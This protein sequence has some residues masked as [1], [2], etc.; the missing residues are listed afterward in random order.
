[1]PGADEDRLQA[2]VE[3]ARL[4]SSNQAPLVPGSD[5]TKEIGSLMQRARGLAAL[6]VL[7]CMPAL[8][9]QSSSALAS[10]GSF[11]RYTAT[12]DWSHG[13]IAGSVIWTECNAGCETWLAL[14]YVQPT[15]YACYAEEWQDESDPNIRQ[16]YNSGGQH[17]NT[18][19]NFERL[20]QPLLPGVYG[21]RLCMI[22]VQSTRYGT[23]PDESYVGQ[24][25]LANRVMEVEA[26]APVPLPPPPS[27]AASPP[28]PTVS[29]QCILASREVR[30]LQKKL[31]RAVRRGAGVQVERKALAKAKR[32]KQVDC[33]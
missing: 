20:G 9:I 11:F 13:D 3:S 6:T 19:I 26:P 28:P 10:T 8:A 16:I 25:V 18:T 33:Q 14:V 7:L 5:I 31:K 15:I 32:R 29:T 2:S 4:L 30:R 1:M 27:E 21:Q 17:A 24:E 12:P 22:G 23:Y